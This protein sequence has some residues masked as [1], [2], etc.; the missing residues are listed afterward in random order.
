MSLLVAFDLD[1]MMTSHD[2]WG[3]YEELPGVATY[4]L[5]R[6][7]T[8]EGVAAVRFVWTGRRLEEEP[9]LRAAAG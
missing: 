2:E 6:D 3:C 9:E 7:P 4:Q 8:F 1:F 5:Y